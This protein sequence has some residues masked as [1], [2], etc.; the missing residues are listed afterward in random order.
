MGNPE[1]QG[2]LGD[3]AEEI[4]IYGFT[5]ST[6]EEYAKNNGYKFT[7]IDNKIL[8][9]I[10]E[11]Q[12]YHDEKFSSTN[13]DY[14]EIDGLTYFCPRESF[15]YEYIYID[16]LQ[17]QCISGLKEILT[18]IKCDGIIM[19]DEIDIIL[20]EAFRNGHLYDSVHLNNVI[21]I[22]DG[23]F[24]N[25]LINKI[26]L[27]K[28]EK[29]GS[30]A[31]YYCENLKTITI[32]QTVKYIGGNAFSGTSLKEIYFEGNPEKIEKLGLPKGTVIY[33]IPGGTVEEYAKAYGYKFVDITKNS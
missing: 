10:I 9:E 14:V 19:P 6:A 3:K 22:F 4:T 23:A 15:T 29:I 13:D 12:K 30:G 33:G 11:F 1:I 16:G 27:S 26:D 24:M 5:N 2:S 20:S 18:N 17:Y 8:N 21:E 32:P 31:F 28:V 7:T 25:Q